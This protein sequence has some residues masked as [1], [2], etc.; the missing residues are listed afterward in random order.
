MGRWNTWNLGC[1]FNITMFL[2]FINWCCSEWETKL[3]QSKRHMDICYRI[4]A[5]STL[6]P[7]EEDKITV[8]SSP[9]LI[10][11]RFL[12]YL[13][14]KNTKLH[15]EVEKAERIQNLINEHR[16]Q[17]ANLYFCNVATTSCKFLPKKSCWLWGHATKPNKTLSQ[18]K[19]LNRSKISL[20]QPQP[21]NIYVPK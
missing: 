17:N 11:R 21:Q 13:G 18:L 10:S 20:H 14:W 5:S 19:S 16:P 12:E 15:K 1:N 7:S 3:L 8:F 2:H 6:F 4:G 9:Y